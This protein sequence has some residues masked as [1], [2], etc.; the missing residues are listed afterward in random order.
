MQNNRRFKNSNGIFRA[1]RSRAGLVQHSPY[2]WKTISKPETQK[3]GSCTKSKEGKEGKEGKRNCKT[4]ASNASQKNY[5]TEEYKSGI[6]TSWTSTY[7]DWCCRRVS[8]YTIHFTKSKRVEYRFPGIL[9]VIGLQTKH[10]MIYIW[11]SFIHRQIKFQ[12]SQA[13]I[14]FVWLRT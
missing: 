13:T 1:A 7:T 9:I 3:T 5:C 8:S 10:S 14:L 6:K 2:A 12:S 4:T 11:L